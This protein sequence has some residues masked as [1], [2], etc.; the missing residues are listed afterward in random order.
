VLNRCDR[1]VAISQALAGAAGR[2]GIAPASIVV[3]P[4]GVDVAQFNPPSGPRGAEVVFVGSLI[5]RKGVRYLLEAMAQ[6][7]RE[8]P[9]VHLT[10]VGD[11]P[12]RAAL[13]STTARLG[14]SECVTFAGL[15][16]ADGVRQA[17]QKA[18]AF[19]LPSVEEGLGVVLLEALACGTP[20]VAS[21][22]GGIP[23]AVTAD[24]GR[25][26]PPADPAAL[27]GGLIELL[28]DE[29]GWLEMSRNARR[30]AEDVYDWS[31]IAAR[32]IDVYRTVLPAGRSVH[33]KTI[34][35]A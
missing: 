19:V 29:A 25:L 31:K 16:P 28:R 9:A 33:G 13:E 1:I 20:I 14:L 4:L 23:E 32:L 15:L 22:V 17:M 7:R 12:E 21:R 35:L 8:F 34:S 3:I 27:A 10:V 18:R 5:K 2:L 24:A 11:G 6:V 26:V 30:R